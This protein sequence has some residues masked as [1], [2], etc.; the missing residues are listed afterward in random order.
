MEQ[1]QVE[2]LIDYISTMT[3]KYDNNPM[4]VLSDVKERDTKVDNTIEEIYGRLGGRVVCTECENMKMKNEREDRFY[5]P[6]CD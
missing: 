5:C 6:R 3:D 4:R 1:R 2:K